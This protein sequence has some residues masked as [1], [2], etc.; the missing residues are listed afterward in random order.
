MSVENE[1]KSLINHIC[2]IKE[3]TKS[4]FG[5]FCTFSFNEIIENFINLFDLAESDLDVDY[6]RVGI[7]IFR[8][9]IEL[10]N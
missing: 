2:N 6:I 4:D 8:K 5:G 9:I 10:E 7:K 3:L 1:F